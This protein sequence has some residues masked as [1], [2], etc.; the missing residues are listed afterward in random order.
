M[1]LDVYNFELDA[2]DMKQLDSLDQNLVTA[3]DPT[4]DPV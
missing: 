1:N 4:V 2:T 3:W